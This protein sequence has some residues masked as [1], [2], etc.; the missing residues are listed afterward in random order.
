MDAGA[1]SAAVLAEGL[2]ERRARAF[3]RVPL[4]PGALTPSP[5][6]PNVVR[7]DEVRAAIRRALGAVGGGHVTLVLPDGVARVALVDPPTDADPRDYVRFRLA[8]SLPWP[9]SE[10]IVDTLAVG[11]GR[12]IGAAVRRATVTEYEQ[13]TAAAGAGV[14]RVHLAPLLAIEGLMRSGARGAVH[15]VLGD[16]AL[17]LAPFRGGAP[18]A[19]RNRRRDRSPGEAARLREE[20]A[21]AAAMEGDGAGPVPLVVSGTDAAHLRRELGDEGG[22]RGLDGPTEWAD[23]AEAA[24]LGGLLA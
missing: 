2:G 16:V 21:R 4:E 18:V 23:A 15:A 5:S 7:G 17:C 9:A 3:A 22:E 8:S 14:E 12:A 6:G 10:A 1:V 19:L 20:A 11:R 24:W 13:A